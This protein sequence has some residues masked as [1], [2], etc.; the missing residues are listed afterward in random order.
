LFDANGRALEHSMFW[1]PSDPAKPPTYL[2]PETAALEEE[3][4]MTPRASDP[5]SEPTYVPSPD[6]PVPE[7]VPPEMVMLSRVTPAPLP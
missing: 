5:R 3:L 4:K 1:S 7:I 6:T 2:L